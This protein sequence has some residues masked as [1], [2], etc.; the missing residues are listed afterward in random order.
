MTRVQYFTSAAVVALGLAIA[1]AA[2]AAH[3]GGGGG[4]GGGFGGH[5]FAGGF[6]GGGFH[7]GGF[8]GYGPTYG[9]GMLFGYDDAPYCSQYPNWYD[10]A[11]GCFGSN[12]G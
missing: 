2:F 10:P 12:P 5:G 6:H 11:V 1:P 3:G 8:H 9:G 4:N 7:G